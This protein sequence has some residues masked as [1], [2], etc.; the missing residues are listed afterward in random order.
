L[1]NSR[2]I[3]LNSPKKDLES[4][5]LR[6]DNPSPGVKTMLAAFRSKKTPETMARRLRQIESDAEAK[7]L[8]NEAAPSSFESILRIVEQPAESAKKANPS[9]GTDSLEELNATMLAIIEKMRGGTPSK[10]VD[11]LQTARLIM[12]NLVTSK[13]PL[14]ASSAPDQL[15]KT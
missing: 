3:A 7:K 15:P 2:I 4:L 6:P 10:D 9:A 11:P 12:K 1:G 8:G 14:R 5:G 13:L